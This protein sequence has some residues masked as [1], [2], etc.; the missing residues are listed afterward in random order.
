MSWR[1]GLET[2]RCEITG[3]HFCGGTAVKDGWCEHHHPHVGD[4]RF[5]ALT[6]FSDMI[7]AVEAGDMEAAQAVAKAARGR[8]WRSKKEIFG[9]SGHG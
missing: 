2:C 9:E 4:Q 3:G 5:A 6:L 8:G 1:A 7:L